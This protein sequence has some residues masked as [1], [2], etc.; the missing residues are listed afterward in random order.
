MLVLTDSTARPTYNSQLDQHQMRDK[1]AETSTS[2]QVELRVSYAPLQE[3][4]EGGGRTDF[5]QAA[6]FEAI[7]TT[8]K[9]TDTDPTA[10]SFPES[11]AFN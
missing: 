6:N 4:W 9:L 1:G 3:L 10:T 5:A 2:H 11:A 8:T 7:S